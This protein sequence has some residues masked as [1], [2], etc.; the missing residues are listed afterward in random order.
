PGPEQRGEAP[1]AADAARAEHGHGDLVL[2]LGEQREPPEGAPDM[3][4]GLPSLGD[5]EIAARLLRGH[6][7][8][9]RADLPRA[10]RAG[11][12]NELDELRVGVAPEEVD[13]LRLAGR[14]LEDVAVQVRDQEID[15]EWPGG[16]REERVQALLGVSRRDAREG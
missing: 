12:V 7:L 2:H 8:D 9:D 6:G 16:Q 15:A 14:H 4:N 5:Y 11:F 10:Q 13:D 3:A 1:A